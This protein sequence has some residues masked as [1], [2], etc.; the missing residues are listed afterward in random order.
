MQGL[1]YST[2]M[3]CS[4]WVALDLTQLDIIHVMERRGTLHVCVGGRIKGLCESSLNWETNRKQQQFFFFLIVFWMESLQWLPVLTWP[5]KNT[6]VSFKLWFNLFRIK[7]PECI[8]G[9]NWTSYIAALRLNCLY[10]ILNFPQVKNGYLTCM[11]CTCKH[12]GQ[13]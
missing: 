2:S 13:T 5:N 11:L 6:Q 1:K 9:K 4:S 12:W 8:I 3:Q 7:E 10:I